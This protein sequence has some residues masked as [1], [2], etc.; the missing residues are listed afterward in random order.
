MISKYV[1]QMDL[2][3]NA[4]HEL[5]ARKKVF[6]DVVKDAKEFIKEESKNAKD[7]MDALKIAESSAREEVQG[8]LDTIVVANKKLRDEAKR[9]SSIGD[10]AGAINAML[11]VVDKIDH[12]KVSYTIAKNVS[13]VNIGDVPVEYLIVDKAKILAD[14]KKNSSIKVDGIEFVDCA[15]LRVSKK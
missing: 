3:A 7:E 11:K 12:P 5:S 13:I 1:E 14:Y 8:L 15:K 9:L 6:D 10:K 4:S 2:L